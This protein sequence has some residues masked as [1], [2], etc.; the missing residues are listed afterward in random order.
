[1]KRDMGLIRTLLE[2]IEDCTGDFID[3]PHDKSAAEI[4]YHIWLLRDA[5]FIEAVEMRSVGSAMPAD[6]KDI[7]LTWQGHDY[8]LL[9]RTED[10]QRKPPERTYETYS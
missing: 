2:S 9:M 7:R 3:L 10:Q 4:A 5:G 6:Y 1:M 8:L